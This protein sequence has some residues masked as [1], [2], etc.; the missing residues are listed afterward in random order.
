MHTTASTAGLA[1][2]RVSCRNLTTENPHQGFL[3]TAGMGSH[4]AY[5]VPIWLRNPLY[6]GH[7]EAAG[8]GSAGQRG[9]VT[10]WE[11][12]SHGHWL[13]SL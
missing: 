1:N 2:S 13:V 9:G 5:I 11:G 10:P 4:L 7:Q 12:L 8:R 3:L 6:K